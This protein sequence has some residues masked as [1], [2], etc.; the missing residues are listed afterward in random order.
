[1]CRRQGLGGRCRC[2]PP[3]SAERLRQEF[4]DEAIP[5]VPIL[6]LA[7]LAYFPFLAWILVRL[8]KESCLWRHYSFLL[9]IFAS[10][11][12]IFMA[13]PTRIDRPG[14]FSTFAGTLVEAI[15]RV[16][17]D[18]NAFPS[19]H[20]S[21]TLFGT[22]IA[23]RHGWMS[24]WTG[25]GIAFGI[26]F[27]AISIKQHYVIDALGGALLAWF[28]CRLDGATCRSPNRRRNR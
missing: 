17:S 14:D 27:S 2:L 20:V 19:F 6:A 18:G 7:Y 8:S 24:R 9:A 15:R 11:V 1:M 3:G 13:F 21:L 28:A 16:D 26:V 22:W 23:I 10:S 12:L 5:E 25:A 4:I